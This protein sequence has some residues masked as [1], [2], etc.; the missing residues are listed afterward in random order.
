MNIS[1]IGVGYVGLVT[2]S[3]F[4]E[5]GNKVI[6]VDNDEQKIRDLNKGILPIY[7]H[8][9]Q[10]IVDKNLKNG[11]L[12]FGLSIKESLVDSDVCIIAVGTP[13]QE[14]GSVNLQYI[15]EVAQEIGQY[16]NEYT[17]IIIKSTVPVGTS[18]LVQ[19][20]IQR[21]I[22]GRNLLIDFDVVSNPEFLQEGSAVDNFMKPDRIIIGSDSERVKSIMNVLYA[23]FSVKKSK[24]IFMSNTD[25][26]LTK[27][28]ANAMLATKISFINEIS[29]I[30]D[31][32]GVDIE[33]VRKGIGSDSR[34]GYSFI[35][36]GVGY[37][38]SCFPKDVQGLIY[39][40]KQLHMNCPLLSAVEEV[41]NKQKE[42]MFHKIINLYGE[43]LSDFTFGIWGLSFKPNTDDIRESPALVMI[44]LILQSGG[45]VR[46]YDPIALNVVRDLI[47]D[48]ENVT[49]CDDQYDALKD[50]SALV[51]MTEWKQFRQPNFKHMKQ[52]MDKP[53]IF[54]GRNQ[55]DPTY[56]KGFGFLYYGIGR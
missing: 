50:V 17:T 41:N 12:S 33:N 18:K 38:G 3:C 29:S 39:N 28:T 13:P 16:I 55:Y 56:I 47:G 42:V 6:C 53:V 31:K 46:L 37:G 30:C 15:K 4:C 5:M 14:D 24:L 32:L 44:H 20:I 35:Y 10:E 25:A 23:P 2:G 7:E 49:Y 11:L 52:I 36:P 45:K 26:E 9:L 8:N 51:L 21:Q 48:N 40:Y 54:D 19:T 34:I 27:Y 22:D 43:D 1:V